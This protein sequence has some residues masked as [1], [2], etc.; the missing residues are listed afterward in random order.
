MNTKHFIISY[1]GGNALH[2]L[3]TSIFHVKKAALRCKKRHN[4]ELHAAT[5][6]KKKGKK[7]QHTSRAP[8]KTC[9]Y[10]QSRL[11]ALEDSCAT[12]MDE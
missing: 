4:H 5:Q 10:R 12:S 11:Q 3:C 9:Y 8:L 7:Y 6:I 1:V 2:F